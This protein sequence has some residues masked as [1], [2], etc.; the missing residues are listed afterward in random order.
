LTALV[1]IDN[2]ETFMEASAEDFAQISQ[3]L[4]AIGTTACTRIIITTRSH[5]TIPFNLICSRVL[6]SGLSLGA[7]CAAF[8]LVY[9]LAPIDETIQRILTAL[10]YHPLSINILANAAVI[11]QWTPI[12]LETAWNKER[13]RLLLSDVTKSKHGNLQISIELSITCP[14][15][16]ETRDAALE[17]LRAAA[18][19][20]Q[21]IHRKDLGGTF[22]GVSAGQLAD[23]LCRASLAYW[24]GDRL[25]LLAPIRLYVMDEYN[26]HLSYNDSVLSSFRS[27]Y[28]HLLE[29]K[30]EA[31][32][33]REYANINRVLLFDVSSPL[34]RSDFDVHLATLRSADKFLY[35]L[36]KYNPQAIS[37]QS[38]LLFEATELCFKDLDDTVA[39][40]LGGCLESICWLEHKCRGSGAALGLLDLAES[41]CQHHAPIC[42]RSLVQ[43]LMLRGVIQQQYWSL[44]SAEDALREGLSIAQGMNDSSAEALLKQ[45]ISGVALRRGNILEAKSLASSTQDYFESKNELSRVISIILH[46]SSIAIEEQDW[47]SARTLLEEAE[48]LD[49]ERPKRDVGRKRPHILYEMAHVEGRAGNTSMALNI[50]DKI[51]NHEEGYSLVNAPQSSHYVSAILAKAYYEGLSRNFDSARALTGRAIHLLSTTDVLYSNAKLVGVYIEIF[52]G[53]YRQAKTLL[54]LFLE[55]EEENPIQRKE[56]L[57][58]RALGEVALLEQRSEEGNLW[59]SKAKLLCDAMEMQPKLLYVA[60]PYHCTLPKEYDGWVKYLKRQ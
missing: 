49:M 43:C 46:R 18:F 45:S 41:F 32:V 55:E 20:P 34:Y 7:A 44:A 40:A 1:V 5:D 60:Q 38:L 58:Y 22:L 33:L 39:L 16:E 23:S 47:P 50:L 59:F 29:K 42:N 25:T 6:V 15:F 8:A 12:Q 52:A 14:V 37:F 26:H 31:C 11:N 30:P 17:L 3:T 19:L 9:R 27:Y 21:G 35:S 2:A 10:D 57:F 36:Y 54:R 56:A 28:Y 4:D 51:L 13:S 48:R 24:L 53:N